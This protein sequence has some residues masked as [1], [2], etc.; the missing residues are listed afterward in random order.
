M[1]TT[2]G[3]PVAVIGASGG[4]GSSTLAL[5]V[6]RRVADTHGRSVVLDLDHGRGGLDVTAG[7]EHLAGHRWEALRAVRG[8]APA[9]ELLAGL[10]EEGGCHVLSGG[11]AGPRSRG[12]VPA[13]V[14]LDVLASLRGCRATLVLDLPGTSAL[15]PAVVADGAR[16]VLLVAMHT[17][18]FADADAVVERLLD[19]VPE[20]ASTP[21]LALVTRGGR[22][23]PEVIDDLVHHL[24]APHLHHLPGDPRVR[25]GSERGLWPG[26]ARD[27]VRACA[28]AVVQGFLAEESVLGRAAS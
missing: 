25:L 20:G 17:R 26:S 18:G 1:D 6:G 2:G 24:G 5:A 19:A 23:H 8:R 16:I 14:V 7:I 4:V 3:S 28:D 10:P 27:A 13:E 11:G 12:G 21:D 15:L 22:L 9:S